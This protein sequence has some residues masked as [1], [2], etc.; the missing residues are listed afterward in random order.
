MARSVPRSRPR[1]R[2][3]GAPVR[4]TGFLNQSEMA[5]AYAL[6]DVL[7]V[8]SATETWGLVVNEAMA[9]GLPAAVSDA[10][11]CAPD[12]VDDGRTGA[13]YA[14]GGGAGRARRRARPR[15]PARRRPR[16]PPSARRQD[17]P[18]LT[19]AGGCRDARRRPRRLPPPRPRMTDVPQTMLPAE[20][21]GWGWFRCRARR[22]CSSPSGAIPL[23]G[24]ERGNIQ[25]FHALQDADVDALFVTNEAYRPRVDPTGA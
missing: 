8:P 14:A 7:A 5:G 15:A 1:S 10:V 19:G 12:L 9:C 25:V 16:R 6:A 17:R 4:L 20:G 22:A 2:G 13:T 18:I 24:Q 11:G 3:R 21:H 23:F